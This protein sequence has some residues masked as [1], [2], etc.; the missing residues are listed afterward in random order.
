MKMFFDCPKCNTRLQVDDS[1]AGREARC[2]QCSETI[3]I[4]CVTP[5]T[6]AKEKSP[7][8]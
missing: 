7:S 2:P 8:K 5:E 3:A 4:P 1:L 6:N